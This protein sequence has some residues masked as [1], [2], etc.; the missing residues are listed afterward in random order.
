MG[1]QLCLTVRVFTA[2]TFRNSTK[3]SEHV[4]YS[5]ARPLSLLQLVEFV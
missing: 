5:S 1:S 3:A 4:L 2:G